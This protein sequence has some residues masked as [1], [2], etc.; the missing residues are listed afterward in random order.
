MGYI[1]CIQKFSKRIPL[2]ILVGC[3]SPRCIH[4]LYHAVGDEERLL[5][6]KGL[7]DIISPERFRNDMEDLLH[8][9]KPIRLEQL[10]RYHRTG[11]LPSGGKFF[12]LSFDDGL[13]VTSD[14]SVPVLLE[15][16]IPAAFFVNTDFIGNS[17]FLHRFKINLLIR[18]IQSDMSG[19][20]KT[21]AKQFFTDREK[22]SADPIETI[23]GL[24]YPAA[25]LIDD[26]IEN[27]KLDIVSELREAQPYM[28]LDDLKKLKGKGFAIGTH[29]ASHPEY[30]LISHEEQL[31][32][33]C[34]SVKQ[35]ENWIAPEYNVFAF[36]FT[37]VGVGGKFF[38]ELSKRCRVDLSFGTSGIK[39]DRVKNHL[40]RI[41]M[42]T[43]G[44]RATDR[45]KFELF[46]YFLKSFLGKNTYNRQ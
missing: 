31:S 37:D 7:Y 20:L 25:G 32:Q 12:F 17:S 23:G 22:Y 34:R 8:F 9:Y 26:L 14:C 16:G 28:T 44:L 45:L 10:I 24:K 40:N 3:V 18:S 35:L 2:R 39:K 33:T 46:Y 11:E 29:S 43:M 4:L 15:L 5:Y 42:D 1:R 30:S 13:K 41:P 36:P 21:K 19:Q 6:A 27:L 38:T